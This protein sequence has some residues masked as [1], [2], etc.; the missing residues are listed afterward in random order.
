MTYRVI[1]QRL[2]IQ[3]LDDAFLW[4][5]RKAPATA[6]YRSTG[7]RIGLTTRGFVEPKPGSM[8]RIGSRQT[9]YARRH[10]PPTGGGWRCNACP[11]RYL[12]GAAISEVI[13]GP[14]PKARAGPFQ[15]DTV[16]TFRPATDRQS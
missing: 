11:F 6:A 4:A 12:L 2:A 14:F 15:E 5:A 16:K 9:S 13:S 7:S 10:D 8:I 3:D 1:L